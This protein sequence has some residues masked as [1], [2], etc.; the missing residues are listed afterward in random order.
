ME[1]NADAPVIAR[2]EIVVRAPIETVWGVQTDV[3]AWPSW[4]PDVDEVRADGPLSVGSTFRWQTFGLDI[5]STVE[6]IEAPGR[7]VWSGPAGGI[8]AVHVWELTAREDGVL[9][10]T[11]ESW[12]G[13]EVRAQAETLQGALDASLRGWLQNLKRAAEG[14]SNPA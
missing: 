8:F 9:V 2:D 3:A 6:E 12:E 10:R 13:E 1:I 4:Q 14:A 5:T 11:E 7:V